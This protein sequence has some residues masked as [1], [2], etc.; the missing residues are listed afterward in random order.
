M[1]L[2]RFFLAFNFYF[3]YLNLRL[4]NNLLFLFLMRQPKLT[5]SEASAGD[6]SED[7]CF[8]LNNYKPAEVKKLEEY[9][10]EYMIFGYE[11]APT[12]G[13]K[14]LQ[15]FMQFKNN[16]LFTTI[17][18]DFKRIWLA[19]REGSPIQARNYCYYADYPANTLPNDKLFEKGELI[20]RDKQGTRTDLNQIASSILTGELSIKSILRNDPMKYHLYGRTFEKLDDLRLEETPRTKKCEEC[21][22]I[23]GGSGLGKSYTYW[24][25]DYALNP[26]KYYIY[27]NDKE[28]WCD[29]YRGQEVFVLDEFRG[30]ITFKLLIELATKLGLVLRR[31]G[32]SPIPFTS[33]KI[34]ITSV[35]PIEK[36][37]K[38]LDAE[39]TFIQFYR[40]FTV[41]KITEKY[42]EGVILAPS[43]M[44][45]TFDSLI[46]DV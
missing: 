24:E 1:S 12:T 11:I 14:H 17:K 6:K 18:K 23:F 33:R 3:F 15:G 16:K 38:N 41:I 2:Y 21:F 42:S 43:E 5:K 8:T 26:D 44:K 46:N 32:R 36:I 19:R 7:W 30:E 9:K 35:L 22:Y 29:N 20:P 45:N 37:Y 13:T 25:R 40:R 4:N 34:V 39:D 27:P 31:R 28:G 10:C